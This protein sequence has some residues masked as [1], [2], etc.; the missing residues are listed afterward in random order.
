M[1]INYKKELKFST[2]GNNK[3]SKKNKLTYKQKEDVYVKPKF[4]ARQTLEIYLGLSQGVDVS[5]Y[6]K[7][8]FDFGQMRQ[9][10]E[11]LEENL[12]VSLYAKF[13][14]NSG[15]MLQIR[16]G[17]KQGLDVSI[18]AKP[19]YTWDQMEIIKLGLEKGLDVSIYANPKISRKGM[20]NI[21]KTVFMRPEYNC[22]SDEDKIKYYN[23]VKPLSK[24]CPNLISIDELD[25]FK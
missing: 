6:T 16:L 8:E 2:K 25:K 7:S 15:Q 10:R 22:Y 1:K 23:I 3:I 24:N 5:I 18:Y 21:I 17:L 4:N 20:Y 11:G 14:F 9:I 12:D 19:E 13:E